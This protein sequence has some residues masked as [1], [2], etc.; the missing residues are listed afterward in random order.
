MLFF[1]LQQANLTL[2][3]KHGQTSIKNIKPAIQQALYIS[4][5]FCIYSSITE[6]VAALFLTDVIPL[7]LLAVDSYI[8]LFPIT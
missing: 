4:Y 2:H 7:S 6:A 5:F 8:S 1:T 3:I